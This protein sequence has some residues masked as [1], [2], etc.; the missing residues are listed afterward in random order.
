MNLTALFQ[1]HVWGIPES[2]NAEIE[3]LVPGSLK[4]HFV[5]YLKGGYTKKPFDLQKI[6]EVHT[7]CGRTLAVTPIT[8]II[9]Y[10]KNQIESSLSV[11]IK[12]QF[13]NLS[14]FCRWKQQQLE[15]LMGK[16]CRSQ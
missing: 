13:K 16:I 2:S 9:K 3:F 15:F 14:H 6:P 4:K 12:N 7:T 1:R 10:Q 5:V 8:T 11:H